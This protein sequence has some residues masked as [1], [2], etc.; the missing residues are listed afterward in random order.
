MKSLSVAVKVVALGAA[1]IGFVADSSANYVDDNIETTDGS[2]TKH[3]VG[4]RV[5]Y[6]FT[7]V[8]AAAS[9]R[10]LRTMTLEDY[11]LVG[12]G[13]AGGETIGGGGGGGGVIHRVE[14]LHV[15]APNDMLQVTVGGGGVGKPSI[16]RTKFGGRGGNGGGVLLRPRL[17]RLSG[18]VRRRRRLR[19]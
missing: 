9:V 13:G 15:I 11:L 8:Q 14:E 7:N 18:R 17:V 12:G 2:V 5:V 4:D 16:G 3:I 1:F 10:F 19:F 6:V